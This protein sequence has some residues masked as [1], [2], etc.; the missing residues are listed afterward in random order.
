MSY[1]LT[2]R[3]REARTDKDGRAPIT[4]DVVWKAGAWGSGSSRRV[5]ALPTG[6]TCAKANWQPERDRLAAAAGRKTGSASN[7][8]LIYT[9]EPRALSKNLILDRIKTTIGALFAQAELDR[10]A[11]LEDEVRAAFVKA[12]GR[13]EVATTPRAAGLPAKTPAAA[14]LGLDTPL[15]DFAGHWKRLNEGVL[16]PKTLQ[17][18]NSQP[19]WLDGFAPGM[20]LRRFTREW[21]TRYAAYLY[22]QGLHDASV[23]TAY[24][25]F[26]E[27]FKMAGQPVPRFLLHANFRMARK[28]ALTAN[29]FRALLDLDLRQEPELEAERDV[30]VF[31]AL[32]LLRDVDVR[33]LRPY[34]ATELQLAPPWHQVTGLD[35]VQT[36]TSLP[37]LGVMPPVAE[38]IWQRY[39]GS[40][41]QA[42]NQERNRRIKQVA[43]RAKLNRE[44]VLTQFAGPNRTEEVKL[45]RNV[46]STHIARHT[47]ATLLLQG[48]DGDRALKEIA[49]G[50]ANDV[51]GPADVYQYGPKILAAW[52]RVLEG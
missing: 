49:L 31:Q 35:L 12:S 37:I 39:A 43:T 6:I 51:Y 14:Q 21:L 3:L 28:P 36:K 5:N 45:L 47:G 41:P 10:R 29:E 38:Q 42:T 25:Y 17:K 26:R 13:T 15:A 4:G 33:E 34:R 24:K 48:S 22:E 32:L 20:T 1:K 40:F 2:F 7:R 16:A 52:K 8:P 27:A 30:W 46:I 44:I 19:E 23:E 9:A 18:Y 50:H 11:P